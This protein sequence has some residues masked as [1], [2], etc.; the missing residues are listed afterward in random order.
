MHS[1]SF[2]APE[3]LSPPRLNQVKVLKV[4]DEDGVSHMYSTCV[5]ALEC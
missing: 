4:D 2:E 1:P 5:F 3:T